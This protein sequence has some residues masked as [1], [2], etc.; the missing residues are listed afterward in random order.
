MSP[1]E[2][3]QAFQRNHSKYILR[4]HLVHEPLPMNIHCTCDSKIIIQKT[5]SLNIYCHIAPDNISLSK[6][7]FLSKSVFSLLVLHR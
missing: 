4:L 1:G 7:K 2:V 3:F 5:F 6:K